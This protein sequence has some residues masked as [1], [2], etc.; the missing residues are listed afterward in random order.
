[1]ANRMILAVVAAARREQLDRS[2]T[3]AERALETLKP[4]GRRDRTE[5][6]RGYNPG[7]AC[8]FSREAAL[9]HTKLPNPSDLGGWARST[10]LATRS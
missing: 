1:M 7:T 3:D 8:L 9:V 10:A 4:E 6:E 5:R 2:I